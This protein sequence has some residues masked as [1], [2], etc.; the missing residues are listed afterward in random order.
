ML[1]ETLRRTVKSPSAKVGAALFFIMCLICILAPVLAP[2]G[3]NEMDMLHTSAGPGGAHLMGT[4]ML[5]RDIFPGFC[6][7]AGI[8]LPWASARRFSEL[9]WAL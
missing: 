9:Q 1:A 6:M 7:G 8:P 2:Y 3:Q 4:D 5:G